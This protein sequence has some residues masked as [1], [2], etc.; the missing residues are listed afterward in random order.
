MSSQQN[1]TQWVVGKNSFTHKPQST[2]TTT[3]STPTKQGSQ[4]NINSKSFKPK[5]TTTH[6]PPTP[7]NPT[8]APFKPTPYKKIGTSTTPSSTS[9]T[10]STTPTGASSSD[11][12]S[13]VSSLTLS[14]GAVITID[15][16]VPESPAVVTS[17]PV[18]SPSVTPPPVQPEFVR[19][20][21]STAASNP[22]AIPLPSLVD[23]DE[24]EEGNDSATSSNAKESTGTVRKMPQEGVIRYTKEKILE[25]KELAQPYPK[26][27]VYVIL[28]RF[29][30]NLKIEAS[31]HD[32]TK[33]YV[34]SVLNKIVPEN[35][36][37]LMKEL[38]VIDIDTM[39]F[40][41]EIV[42]IIFSKAVSEHGRAEMYAKIC[43]YLSENLNLDNVID[44][45][46]SPTMGASPLVSTGDSAS[47]ST[48]ASL[49]PAPAPG[50]GTGQEEGKVKLFKKALL[51]VC[52]DEIMVKKEWKK[53]EEKPPE[54]LGKDEEDSYMNRRFTS[55]NNFKGGVI[56]IGELFNIGMI[57]SRP[58]TDIIRDLLSNT[59][60]P[61]LEYIEPLK[62]IFE[63]AGKKLS[64]LK[65]VKD[66][67]AEYLKRIEAM[68]KLPPEILPQRYRFFLQDILDLSERKWV[69][70]PPPATSPVLT[71]S[72]GRG[73]SP[74]ASTTPKASRGPNVPLL[75]EKHR[76]R[77][78]ATVEEFFELFDAGEVLECVKEDIKEQREREAFLPLAF[79]W[80]F[81]HGKVLD[82]QYPLLIDV[83]KRGFDEGVFTRENFRYGLRSLF[84]FVLTEDFVSDLSPAFTKITGVLCEKLI[85]W[86]V[87][88]V[89][90]VF[91][92]MSHFGKNPNKKQYATKIATAFCLEMKEKMKGVNL[93]E[94]MKKLT[95][96]SFIPG[97]IRGDKEKMIGQFLDSIK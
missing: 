13:L 85:E 69:A 79:E 12:A 38:S 66:K 68:T 39:K 70:A 3:S 57:S 65:A 87:M 92:E 8:S 49:S 6:T 89:D 30:P 10:A 9:P 33:F 40:L 94:A 54:G 73:R 56:F 51:H 97:N 44:L 90:E 86:D 14:E 64:K 78:F 22:K 37:K 27:D 71:D 4:F 45:P 24:E 15:T 35:C 93:K 48:P 43:Q 76:K 19:A 91:E 46:Q 32:K 80:T 53:F 83:M 29:F 61:V 25:I 88:R 75:L 18:K 11:S 81:V 5:Q 59:T 20:V 16:K 41:D 21:S 34:Q 31:P 63:K 84:N 23:E 36:D 47:E 7:F 72:A 67:I 96:I 62:I 28:K 58:V 26:R 50:A 2:S 42:L 52:Q 77:V 60:N 17:T 55:Y 74:A 82:T 1:S 95:Y